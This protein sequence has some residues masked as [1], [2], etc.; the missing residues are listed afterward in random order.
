[1]QQLNLPASTCKDNQ[2]YWNISTE[3]GE[4]DRNTI[5]MQKRSIENIIHMSI[6]V[7]TQ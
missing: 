6:C 7:S 3:Y 2:Y 1:M 4:T 5:Q